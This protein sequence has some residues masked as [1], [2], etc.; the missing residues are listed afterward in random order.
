M[1]T[2]SNAYIRKILAGFMLAAI[3]LSMLTAGGLPAVHAQEAETPTPTDQTVERTP[4]Q[5]G[6]VIEEHSIIGLV[7]PPPGFEE[8]RQPV[9]LPKT[10]DTT[11]AAIG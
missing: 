10:D 2:S 3:L 4:F 1:H 8:E 5:D 7:E 9:I 6:R 11:T